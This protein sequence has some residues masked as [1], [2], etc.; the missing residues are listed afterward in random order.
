MHKTFAAIFLAGLLA[1]AA[2][3][4]A[5]TITTATFG[6]STV[7]SYCCFNVVATQ[8]SA[9]PNE[10]QLTVSLDP[11]EYFVH[12]GSLKVK[13]H[14]GFA[15][16][17]DSS[18]DPSSISISFPAGSAWAT[19]TLET[20]QTGASVSGSGFGDFGYY[21]DNPGTGSSSQTTGPLIFYIKSTNPSGISVTDLIA[22][23]NS[24]WNY[25]A[26]DILDPALT[27]SSNT[28]MAAISGPPSITVST[29]PEPPSLLLLGTGVL[30]AAGMIRRR[31]TSRSRSS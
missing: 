9:T 17:L 23:A 13:N 3:A 24:D 12:S 7:G 10:L 25:F 8:D 6:P 22:N 15:F 26:A 27:S 16:N 1:S 18:L 2:A 14:P 30:G 5:D 31:M 20:L 29:A 11:N 19:P 28:G 4:K 21:F